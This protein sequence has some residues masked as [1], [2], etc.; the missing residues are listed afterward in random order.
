MTEPTLKVQQVFTRPVG[1]PNA[2]KQAKKTIKIGL[3]VIALVFGGLGGWMLFAPLH[4]AV[5]APGQVKVESSRKTIQHLEGGIVAK[6]LVHEGDLVQ[7][8]QTLL[9]LE[10]TQIDAQVNMLKDQMA[11]EQASTARFNAEKNNLAHIAFPK[12]LLEH[13][14][15]STVA[16]IMRNESYLFN[17]RRNTLSNEINLLNGQ[18]REVEGEIVALNDQIKASD[19]TIGY[20][21]DELNA[22]EKLADK[23]FVSQPHLLEF[24]RSLST[25]ED[26]Q[27]EYQANI[28]R[29]RQKINEVGLR[30]A[31][32]KHEYTAQASN[33]LKDSQDK[34][35]DLQERTRI[36]EDVMRR[37]NITSPVTGRVVDLKVHTVGGVIAAREPLMD[38]VPEQRE[39]IVQSHVALSDID[40]VRLGMDA[41][42]RLSAY[43][44]RTTSLVKG[45]VIYVAPDSLVDE[46]S[47]TA[48]YPVHVKVDTKSM[49]E[50]GD[51]IKLYP[52]MPAEVYIVTQTRTAAQYLFEPILS[53][54]RRSF[55]QS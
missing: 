3:L 28:A 21:R 38:I 35:F 13:Q 42:V 52:G 4:G 7:Q 20:L 33:A 48:Y 2:A 29:A 49:Q 47:K 31:T 17:T 1:Y 43:K 9:T 36:P 51:N 11:A 6:I 25:E 15:V 44:Q 10:S 37:Q 27:G 24:K 40:D 18:K 8:G 14:K 46:A 41:E 16:E 5:I 12:I 53:T 19:K 26:K 23:G 30:I 34:I 50:A 39:L 22:N 45:K 54:L 55:R 32:L